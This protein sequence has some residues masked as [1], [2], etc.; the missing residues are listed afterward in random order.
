MQLSYLQE[1]YGDLA[2][3][4]GL[5]VS[6]VGFVVTIS[7]VRKA[8]MAAEEARRASR[9]AVLR[10][11]HQ[12]LVGDVLACLLHVRK[13]DSACGDRSWDEALASCDEAR[14]L[15][16]KVSAHEALN[17]GEKETI[18]IAVEAFGLLIPYVQKIRSSESE[19]D[20]S[21]P[22]RRELHTIITNLSK[23]QGRL[24]SQTFEV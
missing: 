14:T 9:E 8:K 21:A 18:A 17:E 1:H 23:L 16:S 5:L 10:I 20:V 3:V 22:K 2:S 15:L 4:T 24:E 11:K 13:V 12:V 19:R 6:F 7:N